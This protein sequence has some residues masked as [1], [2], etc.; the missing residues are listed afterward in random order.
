MNTLTDDPHQLAFDELAEVALVDFA[1]NVQR[2]VHVGIE[3]RP[4][5]FAFERHGSGGRFRGLGRLLASCLE[6]LF[7]EVLSRQCGQHAIGDT[8]R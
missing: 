5:V 4:H 2:R 1:E 7:R 8:R 3:F 6:Q